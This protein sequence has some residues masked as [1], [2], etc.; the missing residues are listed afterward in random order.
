MTEIGKVTKIDERIITIKC[1]PSPAC[2]SCNGG[3]CG[4]RDRELKVRNTRDLFVSVGDYA[5]IFLPSSQAVMAGFQVFVLP[6]ILFAAFYLAARHFLG[7]EA[8]GPLVLSGLAGLLAGFL[9]TYIIAQG[10]RKLPEIL[11]VVEEGEILEI[12]ANCSAGGEPV[13]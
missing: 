4:A 6:L 8:E 2:H 10:N 12:A 1:R 3:L 13:I 9:F 5:E 7:I 11:R